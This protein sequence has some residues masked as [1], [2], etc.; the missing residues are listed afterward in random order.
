MIDG[1]AKTRQ[2]MQPSLDPS[3]SSRIYRLRWDVA[4]LWILAGVVWIGSGVV[5]AWEALFGDLNGEVTYFLGFA[6]VAFFFLG[7]FA[8]ASVI[9]YRVVI[10]NEKIQI[11]SFLRRQE[12]RRADIASVSAQLGEARRRIVLT[13]KNS[14]MRR[15]SFDDYMEIDQH[16]EQWLNA[17]P[18][19]DAGDRGARGGNV[20]G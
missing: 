10:D 7:L 3:S 17:V 11:F 20:A 6:V 4:I 12:M 5:T 9:Q 8:L 13:P 1:S 16:F 2:S 14:K 19:S 15:L 18:Q